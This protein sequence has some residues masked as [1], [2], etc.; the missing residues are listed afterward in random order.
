MKPIISL[1]L[2]AY[3]VE[4]YIEACI[5]S[6]EAQDLPQ[7]SY[8]IIIVNDGSTD[9]TANKIVKLSTI[10]KNIKVI[11]QKNQGLSIARNNGVKEAKGEY[12]WFID[13]DDVIT[14][15]CIT[16][17]TSIMEDLRLDALACAPSISFKESFPKTFD[18]QNDISKVYQGTEFLLHSNQFVIGAWCYIFKRSFWINNHFSFYPKI[19][20]EDTQLIPYVIS[21]ATKVATLTRFSCYNY[22]QH[23]SS[24]IN[25]PISKHKLLSTTVIVNSHLKY[26]NETLAPKLNQYF[27][28]SASSAFINGINKII[29][30]KADKK[31]LNEFLSKIDVRPTALYGKNIIQRLYQYV[32]LHYPHTFVKLHYLLKYSK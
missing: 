28:K 3:N 9:T 16:T 6:C 18:F 20:Y 25:S 13:S 7:N 24:I 31:T 26:A 23:P 8:E 4:K 19:V 12:I 22:I 30:M 14:R 1:I 21:K 5:N 27:K 10:Y 11:T 32:I 15:N 2:P 17:L 29:Q